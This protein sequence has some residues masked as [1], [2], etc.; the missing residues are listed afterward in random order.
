MSPAN[1]TLANGGPGVSREV[2]MGLEIPAGFSI[3]PFFPGDRI[4]H[5][6]PNWFILE[7]SQGLSQ[8]LD[9]EGQGFTAQLQDY[10]TEE[11]FTLTGKIN[12]DG[13]ENMLIDITLLEGFDTRITFIVKD[14]RLHVRIQSPEELNPED[15]LLPW[16]KAIRE[17]MRLYLKTTLGTLFWRPVMNRMVLTMNPSQRKICLMLIRFTFLEIL[18][19]LLIVI[20]YFIFAP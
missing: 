3:A 15:P 16:I 8:D 6:H 4:L 19:I 1:H 20:G 11:K 2:D 9:Q 10:D 5:L 17:Y 13:P 12:F 14:K 7:F 18:V